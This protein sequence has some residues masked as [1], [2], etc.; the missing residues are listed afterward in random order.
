M[1]ARAYPT[2]RRKSLPKILTPDEQERFLAEF[3]TRYP[4][5]HRDL[6]L[7]RLMLEAGLRV[8]EA[9]ALRPEHIEMNSG[10]VTVREGKGAKDRIVWIGEDLR[11]LIGSWRSRRPDSAY[12][13]PTRTGKRL[14]PSHLWRR[15]RKAARR[16]EINE[17]EKVSPHTLR[18]TFATDYLRQTGN[19]ELVRK[20]LGHADISSTQIYIHLCDTEHEAAM[21]AFAEARN[22]RPI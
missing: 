6:C 19:L 7:C 3:N 5:P 14:D 21:L 15:V 8:G 1:S 11:D 10:Q 16:A 9:V 17:A 18:H 13:F 4:T 20:A 2:T 22:G 12:L